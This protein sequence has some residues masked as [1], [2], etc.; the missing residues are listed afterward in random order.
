MTTIL[1]LD[2][3][4]VIQGY[5]VICN[6]VITAHGYHGLSGDIAQR[7]AHAARNT[8]ALLDL[9]APTVV[10][11]ESPVG[12]YAKSVIPQARVSG[13]VLGVL[14]H[15]DA[16]WH[17]VAPS[18]AK[19]VL[20]GCGNANKAQMVMAAATR[21]GLRGHIA[22]KRGKVGLWRDGAC[23]LSEDEADA[24]GVALAGA[25]LRVVAVGVAA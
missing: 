5:A 11:I 17:E 13:A 24:I 21:L 15:R 20:A 6:G 2:M 14:Y 25:A 23:V 1:G 3:S 4:S 7:C 8:A 19:R 16:L 22:T 9:Y 18:V 12:Q 10:V